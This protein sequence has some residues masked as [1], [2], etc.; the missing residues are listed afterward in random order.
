ME[1]EQLQQQ[2]AHFDRKLDASLKLNE[3]AAHAATLARSRRTLGWHKIFIGAE[4]LLGVGMAGLLGNFSAEHWGEWQFVVPAILLHLWT[5]AGIIFVGVQ[6]TAFSRIDYTAP[7]IAI[8]AQLEQR[9]RS[10][11][12][13]VKWALASGTVF[14]VMWLV[15]GL[16]GFLDINIYTNGLSFVVTN[17]LGSAMLVLVISALWRQAGRFTW[18]QKIEQGMIGYSLSAVLAQLRELAQPEYS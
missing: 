5:I 3:K 10:R 9:A 7:I 15:V 1:L 16:K 13:F 4:L 12:R 14:W 17:V 18:L 2:W 6:L 8:H 11:I